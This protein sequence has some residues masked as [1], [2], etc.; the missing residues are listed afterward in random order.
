[1]KHTIK[2]ESLSVFFNENAMIGRSKG[3]CCP[4]AFRE[5]MYL[6]ESSKYKPGDTI[7]FEIEEYGDVTR[8]PFVSS[9]E[10]EVAGY[11]AVHNVATR[12]K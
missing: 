9:V 2:N 11:D 3:E 6:L 10:Y 8:E 1:M 7:V 5:K 12:K 4:S